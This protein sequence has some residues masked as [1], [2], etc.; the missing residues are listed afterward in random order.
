VITALRR[1]GWHPKAIR[2]VDGMQT[3]ELRSWLL[4]NKEAL[5]HS[6]A[7]GKYRPNP[8]RR[9]EIPK[10]GGKQRLLVP[11]TYKYRSLSPFLSDLTVCISIGLLRLSN[12][13]TGSE[14][15][16]EYSLRLERLTQI[17]SRFHLTLTLSKFSFC[18]HL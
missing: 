13:V 17:D 10:D 3:D 11:F 14:P 4:N 16:I 1:I 6:I 8:V 18:N 12:T 5:I 15:T 2:G 9:V 7:S